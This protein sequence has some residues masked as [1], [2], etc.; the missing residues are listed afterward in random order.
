MT[1]AYTFDDLFLKPRYSEVVSRSTV[2]LTTKLTKNFSLTSPVVSSPMDSVTDDRMAVELMQLGAAGAMH[3]FCSDSDA[4]KMAFTVWKC[5]PAYYPVIGSIGVGDE[6]KK[7][8][9]AF[10]DTFGVNVL[11]ID[12]AHGDHN[13]VIQ[14]LEWLNKFSNRSYFDVIAGNIATADAAKRLQDAGA[15]ALRVGIGGGSV[16]TTRVRTGVGVPQLSAIMDVCE[17][18]TVPVIADGGIRNSGDAAKA[19]AAGASSVMIGSL[20]AGTD[21]APGDTLVI[22][23]WPKEKHYKVYRGSA[24]MSIKKQLNGSVSHVEGTATMVPLRGPVRK[25]MNILLEGIRSSMS[26]LG[27]SNI[28]EFHNNAEFVKVTNAGAIEA[29]PHGLL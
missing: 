24:S 18:A 26:Y 5:A 6:G 1:E 23:E 10:F 16:C 20:F 11:L 14:M 19:L 4:V 3:R 25:V 12:V 15:D 22:G 7:R 8:V 9:E 13:N 29:T 17:V 28:A 2:D 21:E 27:A